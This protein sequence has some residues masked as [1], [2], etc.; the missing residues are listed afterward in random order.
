MFSD[1]FS[2]LLRS[3]QADGQVVD[4]VASFLKLFVTD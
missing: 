1:D 4:V 3:I 2:D